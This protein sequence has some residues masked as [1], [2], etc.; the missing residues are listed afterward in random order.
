MV[1]F[2]GPTFQKKK[3]AELQLHR[4]FGMTLR[5]PKFSVEL[6]FCSSNS[7]KTLF[8]SPGSH[9]QRESEED[10]QTQGKRR[11]T[12]SSETIWFQW[13]TYKTNYDPLIFVLSKLYLH[14][15]HVR[16]QKFPGDG[17]GFQRIIILQGEGIQEFK[18]LEL[19]ILEGGLVMEIP[20]QICAC[21]SSVSTAL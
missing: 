4:K 20:S 11:Q 5:Q 8:T 21:Q 12:D 15:Y 1:L 10:R 16:V 9:R 17:E 2:S 3:A 13:S 7:N 6:L 14:L 18:K 19:N